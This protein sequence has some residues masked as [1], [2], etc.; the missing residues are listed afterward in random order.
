MDRA[1]SVVIPTRNRYASLVR[2]LRSLAAQTAPTGVFEGVVVA[3][4]CEDGTARSVRGLDL[5][6][7]LTVV[8]TAHAGRAAARNRG[9]ARARGRILLFLDDDMEASL[10]L[11]EAH[12]GAHRGGRAAAVLGHFPV[13][14]PRSED[15][16]G[17]LVRTWWDRN[18]DGWRDPAHTFAF[19]DFCTGNVSL[20]RRVFESLGGFDE[21]IPPGAAGED[22]EFGHRLL[23]GGAGMRHAPDAASIHHHRPTF[24][25]LM[26]RARE[27][28]RGHVWMASRHPELRDR[29]P[30]G[31]L[32][33]ASRNRAVRPLVKAF[34]AAPAAAGAA[35]ALVA[36]MGRLLARSPMRPVFRAVQMPAAAHAY[37]CGVHSALP[38]WASWAEFSATG[39]AGTSALEAGA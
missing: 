4:G 23:S 9:A 7:P 3:D 20:P 39:R 28:G 12:L 36:A 5:P 35:G 13:V 30:V 14:Q 17:R 24:A 38:D 37:W 10:G 31:L 19:T 1:I 27:E 29:L 33:A 21:S 25:G 15:Q 34:W 8:E 26:G 16:A 2:C 11:I 22:W 18:F 32:A 6:L